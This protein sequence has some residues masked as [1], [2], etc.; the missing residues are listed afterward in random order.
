MPLRLLS[1]KF[2]SFSPS[3]FLSLSN[4]SLRPLPHPQ[5]LSPFYF[6]PSLPHPLSLCLSL[7]I[8]L[9]SPSL[10]DS[11][12]LL[13]FCYPDPD[14][15]I[16]FLAPIF[17]HPP[18]LPQP[19]GFCLCLCPLFSLDISLCVCLSLQLPSATSRCLP[20]ISP[21]P[22]SVSPTLD[23]GLSASPGSVSLPPS[24]GLSLFPQLPSAHPDPSPP[25]TT[26]P[27]SILLSVA[28]PF[29]AGL[30]SPSLPS[31]LPLSS[32]SSALYP[33][34]REPNC[35]LTFFFPHPD[36][37]YLGAQAQSCPSASSPTST[38][39]FPVS[40]LIS[41]PQPGRTPGSLAA[42]GGGAVRIGSHEG[43]SWGVPTGGSA[44]PPLCIG[45]LTYR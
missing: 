16:L 37:L 35:L 34:T 14:P 1:P 10:D 32:S 4:S 19:L 28:P 5:F 45:E 3:L 24:L 38:A 11:L 18:S 27:P 6:F 21:S 41:T 40:L 20:Q 33:A 26:F 36:P 30:P 13:S 8:C 39:P 25:I 29:S 7:P 9:S 43:S 12:S 22:I 17:P 23:L 15:P 31:S 44:S 2:L 42:G